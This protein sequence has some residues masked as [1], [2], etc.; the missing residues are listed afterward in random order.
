MHVLCLIALCLTVALPLRAAPST[1]VSLSRDEAR[2]LAF[3]LLR[4]NQP[5]HARR[6]ALG[7]LQADAEDYAALMIL[8]RAETELGRHAHG[9]RAG[10][11]AWEASASED[12][13][14]AAA[15][16]VSK[17]LSAMGRYGH[18]Q[19]WLRRAGQA[20]DKVQ[21][22][23]AARREFRKVQA[24]NP[25][26]SKLS[27]SVRPSSN[28]NGGPTTNTFTI[29]NFVFVDPTAVP[30]S[31]IEY[32]THAMIRRDFAAASGGP[33]AHL[34]FSI[35]DTRYSLSDA[36]KAAS[37]TARA[38]DF[39]I[40]N[41]RLSG[42]LRFD[43]AEASATRVTLDLFRDYRGGDALANNAAIEVGRDHRRGQARM[44]Y[45]L[46]L[47]HRTRLDR[48]D[49]SSDAVTAKAYWSA[50]V[51]NGHLSFSASVGDIQSASAEIAAQTYSLAMRYVPDQKVFGAVPT[52]EI[53][54]SGRN[55]DR[56]VYGADARRD[57]AVVLSGEL[58][59][60]NIDFYGFAPTVG[61]VYSRN[62]SNVTIFDYEE[63]GMTFGIRST[64]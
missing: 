15:Y 35:D 34:A 41:M 11:R 1:E 10:R 64:F 5:S 58:F 31:G 22:E 26:S 2:T 57:R 25:W 38:S 21:F 13:E 20:S 18:A 46:E 52:L 61:A 32:G 53:A 56:V 45:A 62:T 55:Y 12:Q 54:H 42:G 6:L 9:A 28:I 30:L 39:T 43:G 44:G 37:P 7:L 50:P 59:F 36:A 3:T 19:W 51:G 29:G 33:A 16:M 14:F 4:Q 17:S 63:Y 49:R 8:A 24:M 27:F 47:E 23:Q 40:T 48:G 60:K